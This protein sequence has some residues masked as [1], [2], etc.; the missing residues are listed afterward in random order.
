MPRPR[1]ELEVRL[2]ALL[3]GELSAEEAAALR[4]IIAKDTH[5]AGLHERLKRA[6]DLVREAAATGTEPATSQAAPLRLSVERRQ[7]LLA[8]FKTVTPKE[9]IT[10]PRHREWSWIVPLAAAAAAIVL[11]AAI[12]IP[13]FTRAR[14]SAPA[15]SILNNLRILEGAKDQWALENKKSPTDMVNLGD[16]KDY[17]KGG[18]VRPVLGENYIVG[19]VSDPITADV[20]ADQARKAFGGV[21][22]KQPPQAARGQRARL[23]ADAELTFVDK[24]GM[25]PADTRSGGVS[26]A[27]VVGYSSTPAQEEKRVAAKRLAPSENRLSPGQAVQKGV[28]TQSMPPADESKREVESVGVRHSVATPR[29]EIVLPPSSEPAGTIA[30]AS[31]KGTSEQPDYRFFLNSGRVEGVGGVAGIGGGSGGGFG[32]V[33]DARAGSTTTG[34]MGNPDWVGVPDAPAPSSLR[35]TNSFIARNALALRPPGAD[36]DVTALGLQPGKP[37]EQNQPPANIEAKLA[38]SSQTDNKALG[39]GWDDRELGRERRMGYQTGAAPSTAG[40]PSKAKPGIQV[41]NAYIPSRVDKLDAASSVTTT[42]GRAMQEQGSE[43]G[44]AG[45][46][47]AVTPI[48]GATSPG[49]PEVLNRYTGGILLGPNN[50]AT[51]PGSAE[52]LNRLVESDQLSKKSDRNSHLYA[53]QVPRPGDVPELGR[54]FRANPDASDDEGK[55]RSKVEPLPQTAGKDFS[56]WN[57]VVSGVVNRAAAASEE[58]VGRKS[59]SIVLPPVTADTWAGNVPS[60]PGRLKRKP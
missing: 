38:E 3:L 4:E 52:V 59:P 14:E 43:T 33:G 42:K 12:T 7:K 45:A 6:I 47:H 39:F 58:A 34:A 46:P 49:N 13:N 31:A 36:G 16:L 32:Q 29:Q 20:D 60:L 10:R 50:A 56:T 27:T 15:N 25:T 11:L 21:A 19:R 17:L 8:H 2:T 9:F 26:S 22:T 55:A 51:S 24:N 53:D 57:A 54:L 40:Q 1:E 41:E 28:G 35:S 37:A 48:P 18:T 44:V 30:T 23:N 5:L